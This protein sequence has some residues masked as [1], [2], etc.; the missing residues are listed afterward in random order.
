MKTNFEF[1]LNAFLR[2]RGVKGVLLICLLLFVS[3]AMYAQSEG[4]IYSDTH[5]TVKGV[6][7][8]EDRIE[9]PGVHIRMEGTKDGVTTLPDGS[10]A[11]SIPK[12]K[13][14]T[15]VY[16]FIGMR[17]EKV[18]I[19]SGVKDV[20]KNVVMKADNYRLDEVVIT[21]GYQNIDPRKSTMAISS[22]K[23]EDVLQPHMTTIDQALEG[24][25][26]ACCSCR[27][28]VKPVLRLVSVFVVHLPFWETVNRFGC[29]MVS[30][31][32]IR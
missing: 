8:D 13:K 19:E 14:I 5:R 9:L 25:I 32:K 11:I 6:V 24:R 3:S 20:K 29:W 15:L 17:E 22:V 27:I 21:T 28:P 18:V 10:Y 2:R 30:S 1:E 31:F 26:P 12:N 7:F 23:M 4:S 16:S